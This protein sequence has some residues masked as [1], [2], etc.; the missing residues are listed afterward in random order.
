MFIAHPPVMHSIKSA[1]LTLFVAGVFIPASANSQPQDL[2]GGWHRPL[3]QGAFTDQEVQSKI[4]AD[5]SGDGVEDVLIQA[6]DSTGP[7]AVVSGADGTLWFQSWNVDGE[8]VRTKVAD[9]DGDGTA[10]VLIQ[11]PA[12]NGQFTSCGR[13]SLIQGGTATTLWQLEGWDGWTRLGRNVA[14]VNTDGD[15]DQDLVA[16]KYSEYSVLIDGSTGTILWNFDDAGTIMRQT[17]DYTGDGIQDLMVCGIGELMFLSGASGSEVWRMR[18]SWG[19]SQQGSDFLYLDQDGDGVDEII[20]LEPRIYHAN[21]GSG[22]AACLDGATGQVIWSWDSSEYGA[23][24]YHQPLIADATGDGV[25]DVL[26]VGIHRQLLIDGQTGLEIWSADR[27]VRYDV[28]P[29]LIQDFTGDGITDFVATLNDFSHSLAC[30]DGANGLTQWT[31][32]P[33]PGRDFQV[34]AAEVD[35]VVGVDLILG[36]R[37][38]DSVRGEVRAV[39]GMNGQTI[40]SVMGDPGWDAFGHFIKA[41]PPTGTHAGIVVVRA[42]GET[43]AN[44]LRG[45]DLATGSEIWT[46]P[47]PIQDFTHDLVWQWGDLNGDGFVELVEFQRDVL[48]GFKSYDIY[49]GALLNRAWTQ[50]GK[51]FKGFISD[52]NGNGSKELLFMDQWTMAQPNTLRLYDSLEDR[53]T[54]GL[55]LSANTMSAS[56]GGSLSIFVEMQPRLAGYPYQLLASTAGTGP[57]DVDGVLVPLTH[58]RFFTRTANANYHPLGIIRGQGELGDLSRTHIEWHVSPNQLPAS[59]VGSNIYIATVFGYYKSASYSSGVETILITP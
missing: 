46:A 42:L 57:T 58:D 24:R 6:I 14:V 13:L 36:D 7:V 49:S 10:D 50:S 43:P 5:C 3:W 44:D 32:N 17:P 53:Y 4:I 38:A 54:T 18:T 12:F 16:F 56:A 37:Q 47:S 27:E 51:E 26:S 2:I 11:E 33:T 55:A 15:A 1:F 25:A 28:D 31:I 35:A 40:W 8:T 22:S 45:L 30:V 29:D 41:I 9:F 52:S 48:S 23:F 39:N 21:G 20:I 59:A 19:S 34:E